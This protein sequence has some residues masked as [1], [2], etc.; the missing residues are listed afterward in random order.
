MEY[1]VVSLAERPELLGPALELHA[2]GWPEF[3]QHDPAAGRYQPRLAGELAGYQVLLV[4]EKD[5]LAA[6]GVSIPFAWD[7][8]RVGLPAGWDAVVA[9]GL[10]DLEEGR[11]PTTLSALAAT[12]APDRR[13]QGL[14]PL[15][16]EALKRAAVRHGL[17]HFVAPVRP[18]AKSAYPLTPM[19]RYVRWTLPDGA[20]FDP[21]LRTHWRLGAKVLGVCPRSTVVEASVG[22]WEAWTGM[23]F[24]ETGPYVVPR[25]L[26]PVRVDRE[27]DL[28]RYVE[29]NVWVRHPLRRPVRYGSN[30]PKH[31]S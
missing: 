26:V 31:R 7:G 29:P 18:T 10:A 23:R 30:L 5:E 20:P 1:R 16:I 25:A 27:R 17:A 11:R 9:R 3:L 8:S 13:G 2:L 12:V 14:S 21:W 15:I 22:T 4:D 19:A 6:A 24:P 28:G